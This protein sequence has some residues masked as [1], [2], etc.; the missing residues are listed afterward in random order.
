MPM[1]NAAAAA[2]YQASVRRGLECISV[3]ERRRRIEAGVEA[4]DVSPSAG[5]GTAVRARAAAAADRVEASGA[6]AP[7]ISKLRRQAPLG[8]RARRPA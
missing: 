8:Q 3:G 5:G 2:E 6:G 7:G 4:S 1:L